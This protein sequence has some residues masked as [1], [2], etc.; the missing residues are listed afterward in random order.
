[1]GEIGL[2]IS[3]RPG[4]PASCL[5]TLQ[6]QTDHFIALMLIS[7]PVKRANNTLYVLVM[8]GLYCDH[9]NKLLSTV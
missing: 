5:L 3:I 7:L 9:R 8:A 4:I 6:P 2:L 1:M